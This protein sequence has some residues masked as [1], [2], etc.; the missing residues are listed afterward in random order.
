M[1]R[2]WLL[3]CALGAACGAE[4]TTP[5]CPAAATV[6]LA[7]GATDG[8]LT[9]GF[10]VSVRA[11][12]GN[13]VESVDISGAVGR[14][15]I[16]GALLPAVV[17][18]RV[19][20]PAIGANLYQALAVSDDQWWVLWF[21]CKG[22][23]LVGTYFETTYGGGAQQAAGL[24]GTCTELPNTQHAHVQLPASTVALPALVGG[25]HVDG[26]DLSIA[27]DGTGRLNLDGRALSVYTFSAVDCSACASENG[28]G[29]RELHT[30][31]WDPATGRAC[32]GIFYL[33][34]PGTVKLQYA[35]SL[36]DLTDLGAAMFNADWKL[37]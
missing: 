8:E 7:V 37:P 32:F 4:T 23:A 36:P 25:Y 1:N 9:L 6:P 30:I 21:Y 35:L 2:R 24:G 20:W 31:L 19:P 11:S 16:A 22:G 34:S 15:Q 33:Q 3:L 17:Y 26:P 10:D 27:C 28:I 5:A 13:F 29:W 18:E 14:V 12:A